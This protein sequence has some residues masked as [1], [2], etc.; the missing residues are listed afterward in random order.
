MLLQQ[1][2]IGPRGSAIEYGRDLVEIRRRVVAPRR[3]QRPERAPMTGDSEHTVRGRGQHEASH[4]LRVAPR[5]LLREHSAPRY[6]ED[7]HLPVAEEIERAVGDVRATCTA[8]AATAWLRFRR[9]PACRARWF[10]RP[11]APG[12][13]V[14]AAQRPHRCRSAARAAGRARRRTLAGGSRR[15]RGTRSTRLPL[16]ARSPRR[17]PW[18]SRSSRRRFRWTVTSTSRRRKQRRDAYLCF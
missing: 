1:P 18:S 9:C 11:P 4:A 5:E 8:D 3:H 17:R 10:R 15:P 14:R 16:S 12:E 7:V 13:R 6:A 2:R